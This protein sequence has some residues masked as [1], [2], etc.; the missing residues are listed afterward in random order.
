MTG[1]LPLLERHTAEFGDLL[2]D[3]DL[4]AP[5]GGCPG[6]DLRALAQHLG[7]VHRWATRAVVTGAEPDD[8][9]EG[10]DGRAALCR[11]YA[12][13]ATALVGALRDAGPDGSAWTFGP[14]RGLAVF[15]QRR[16]VHETRLHLWDARASQGTADAVEGG[17]AWDGVR[18]VAEVFYPRQLR[19]GR[20]EPLRGTLVLQAS[21]VGG[22]LAMGE[23][24]RTVVR[25]PASE[26]LLVL[27][28]RLPPPAGAAHLLGGALTP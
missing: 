16:Q 19:R 22:E 4:E 20:L 27:W 1:W 11:W 12:A 14:P 7:W 3:A 13:G 5:V 8:P 10:P 18:V 23:G 9:P 26:L 28:H 17:L 21:D 15:W 2:V 6:W 25:A 24:E